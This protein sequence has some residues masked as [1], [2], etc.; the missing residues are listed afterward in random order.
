MTLRSLQQALRACSP[1]LPDDA[2]R[3]YC[4]VV[5]PEY[6]ARYSVKDIA[7]HIRHTREVNGAPLRV[8]ITDLG[9]EAYEVVIAAR[10]YFSEFA[11]ITGLLAAFGLDIQEGWITTF[12]PRMPAAGSPA[13]YSRN[14]RRPASA[15]GG[16]PRILDVFRVRALPPHRFPPSRQDEFRTELGRLIGL[17]AEDNFQE[18]R[19]RVNRL[20][21]EG[22]ASPVSSS[23]V[24]QPL[25][26][27]FDNRAS[28]AWTGMEIRAPDTPGFLY[29]FSNALAMRGIT[30]HTAVIRTA[31]RTVHD[32]LNVTDRQG[33][34]L[35]GARAQAAL[36]MT[37]VLIKQFTHCLAAAPDPAKA[38]AHFD[39]LL[40]QVMARAPHR[41]LPAFLHERAT[42]NLLARLFGTSDFLWEDF[43]R[44]HLDSLLPVLQDFKTRPLVRP[45]EALRSRLRRQLG[46][47]RDF[48]HRKQI[49]NGFKDQEL[50]RIDM[51]HLMDPRGRLEP[52]SHALT[53]LAEI[54]LAETLST[55]RE[56]LASRFGI[57]RLAD[58]RPCGFTVCGLGKFGG[59]ELG[60]ASDIELLFAYDGP[61]HTDGAEAID[62]TEYFERL[63]QDILGFIE[64]KQEG[65]FHLDVRLRPHGQKGLLASSLGEMETYYSPA[66]LAAPFERQALIKLRWVAGD[67]TLGRQMEALR[68]RFVYSGEP[69]D[70]TVALD[71]RRRQQ[72]ELVPMGAVNVKYSPG[73]L[74]EIEYAAQYLQIL[75]GAR[76]PALRTPST[77]P[78]L[79]ALRRL[80]LLSS[81]DATGLEDA[82]RFLRRLID[83]LRI[84]RGNARDLVLPPPDSEEFT[85]LARRMGYQAPRWKSAATRLQRDIER[86]MTRAHRIFTSRFALPQ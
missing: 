80:R 72:R 35:T 2:I 45:P 61:G 25:E 71:L 39:R 48:T 73:G 11:I 85:F 14:R 63:C 41:R 9:S 84:V 1:D 4:A 76:H 75:H 70:L 20:L 17:L 74:I 49:L 79:G 31:G 53:D 28:R 44:T 64:A 10:D 7:D 57:P 67:R 33:R 29:A 8:R 60:Y 52:F 38:L 86:H 27:R 5:S 26:I 68:D 78:A 24:L 40:D 19:G 55:C 15:P 81:A 30:I 82:Y 43:L 54:I 6:R 22:L 77:L 83:A 21:T 23:G 69:W 66:G 58:G 56:R 62:H 37:A 32:R 47:A 51:R 65:I 36:T 34:K 3:A 16:G 18:A 50:F 59:R 13:S 46:R 12:A 42:L